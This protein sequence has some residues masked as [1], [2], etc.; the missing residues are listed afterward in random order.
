MQWWAL[1]AIFDNIMIEIGNSMGSWEMVPDDAARFVC[2]QASMWTALGAGAKE[3]K[4][5]G[6]SAGAGVKQGG[7][8]GHEPKEQRPALLD[9]RCHAFDKFGACPPLLI[10]V[11]PRFDALV[12]GP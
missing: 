5:T 2:Q 4:K 11:A 8:E 9:G 1:P 3:P 7:Q 10:P 12:D 6:Q